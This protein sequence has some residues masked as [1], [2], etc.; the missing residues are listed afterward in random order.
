MWH[1]LTQIVSASTFECHNSQGT[2]ILDLCLTS[3]PNAM[4]MKAHVEAGIGTSDHNL[5]TVETS[6][7]TPPETQQQPRRLWHFKK[8]DLDGL[9]YF[10]KLFPWESHCFYNNNID[11]AVSNFTATVLI[12]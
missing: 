6:V 3:F 10:Y 1:D 8:G 4:K 11:D 7:G 12:G 2:H 9:R 5:I